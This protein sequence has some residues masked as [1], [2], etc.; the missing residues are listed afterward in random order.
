MNCIVLYSCSY[1]NCRRISARHKWI[2]HCH[3]VKWMSSF[4]KW[5]QINSAEH[6]NS[7]RLCNMHIALTYT[8]SKWTYAFSNKCLLFSSSAHTHTH[9]NKSLCREDD[10]IFFS[11][12]H[13]D[14]KRSIF[15]RSSQ[16]FWFNTDCNK[17]V[18][19]LR[20]HSCITEQ[21]V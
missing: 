6:W 5:W 4:Y 8:Q 20:M 13:S 10:C 15:H 17:I 18:C 9:S 14:P 7:D 12:P 2:S 19:E 1:T 11:F 21:R 3:G 16:F